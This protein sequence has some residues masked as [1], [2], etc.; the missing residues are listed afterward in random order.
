M[1]ASSSGASHWIKFIP[2]WFPSTEEKGFGVDDDS[3]ADALEGLA[4]AS[5]D[6][7]GQRNA[8]HMGWLCRADASKERFEPHARINDYRY[9]A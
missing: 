4:K 1:A 2:E 6:P 9:G 7:M 5:A 3:V 8:N